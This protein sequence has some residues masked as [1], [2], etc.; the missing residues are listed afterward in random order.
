MARGICIAHEI[1]KAR[2]TNS[3]SSYGLGRYEVVAVM[4][5]PGG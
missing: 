2:S 3:G 5:N 4:A 1:A